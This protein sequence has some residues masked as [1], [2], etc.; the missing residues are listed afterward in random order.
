MKNPFVTESLEDF[1]INDLDGEDD[2]DYKG[3]RELTGKE[4]KLEMEVIKIILSN[5]VDL[6]L[7]PNSGQAMSQG[8]IYIRGFKPSPP[9]VADTIVE[10]LEKEEEKEK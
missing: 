8:W 5:N 4:A 3:K 2:E 10:P 1:L 6:L 7:K 9:S